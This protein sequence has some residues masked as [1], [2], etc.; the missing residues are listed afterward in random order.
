MYMNSICLNF[1]VHLPYYYKRY[2]F[3]DIGINHDYYDTLRCEHEVKRASERCYIPANNLMMT[4]IERYPERFS[5][6]LSIS[7][8]ALELFAD[9]APEVLDSFR[10]LVSTGR[11]ELLATPYYHS[12]A[13]LQSSD[14][15]KYQVNL[16]REK[17]KEL[18]GVEPKTF[19]N[20]EMV[21]ADYIGV[22][23]SE[24]GFKGVL[25][26]GAKHVLG[27]RSPNYVYSNP[28]AQNL[29]ILFRNQ[30]MSDDIALRFTNSYWTGYPLTAEKFTDWIMRDPNHRCITLAMDYRV[31]GDY[32]DRSSG[33][34]NFFEYFPEKILKYTDFHFRTPS[35]IFSKMNSVSP[36][37]I[38]H[39]ISWL[40]AERDITAWIGND[41]QK[42]F[43][44]KLF[45]VEE[46]IKKTGDTRLITDW[47][48][49]QAVDN[50]YNMNMRW[51]NEDYLESNV[52]PY[53]VFVDNMNIFADIEIRMQQHK[54]LKMAS[55]RYK[56]SKE[57]AWG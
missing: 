21:Y 27:W 4:L 37:Y 5:F 36:V 53:D 55:T 39:E 22:I 46:A 24:M 7:G 14:E 31:I 1:R 45:S 3:F 13:S 2:N 50:L 9:Y 29:K 56:R 17:M 57:V 51:L 6:S 20:T 43:F 18:F 23:L 30:N 47:R 48:R 10:N 16:H 12:L 28:A 40:S 38:P 54:F 32:M 15:F 52:S 11:V 42:D 26:E 8:T 35:L 44:K 41:L 25:T 49:L 34:F 33:I 19:A